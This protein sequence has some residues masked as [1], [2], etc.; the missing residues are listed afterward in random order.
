VGD[1]KVEA[2][3]RAESRSRITQRGL[4]P[5]AFGVVSR[6]AT[7]ANIV[8]GPRVIRPGAELSCDSSEP[9]GYRLRIQ[10][11]HSPG[12]VLAVRVAGTWSGRSPVI[13]VWRF[14]GWLRV[15]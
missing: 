15:S 11:R 8:L 10:Q 14:V 9:L 6:I 2:R 7:G 1:N 4:S 5:T 3:L 13:S 12:Q